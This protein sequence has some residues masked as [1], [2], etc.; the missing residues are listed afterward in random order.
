MKTLLKLI[1]KKEKKCIA[2]N[3]FILPF[4]MLIS[5]LVLLV[6]SSAL[7]LLSKQ[8]YFS[9]IYKQSQTAYFAADDA[10]TCAIEIDDQYQGSDGLGIFPSSTT[11]DASLY[12]ADVLTYVNARRLAAIPPLPIIV[13]NDIQ[14]AQSAIFDPAVSDFATSTD[15][16]ERYSATNGLE[17]GVTSVYNMRM[18]LGSGEFRCAK[19]TVNKTQTFRQVIAQ[20]Y[21][22]CDDPNGSVERAV[23]N[24]TIS[25]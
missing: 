9:K 8:L 7:T 13:L 14:C 15:F 23:V 5:V 21:A 10:I 25:E 16:F 19:V 24:T 4:T 11:T 3:G 12:I 18:P 6:V 20:G 17:K 22:K 2:R 1:W